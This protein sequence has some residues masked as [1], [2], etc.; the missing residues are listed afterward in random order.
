MSNYKADADVALVRGF[1]SLRTYLFFRPLTTFE[2]SIDN[3]G[4]LIL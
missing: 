3:S 2:H 1:G 4:R